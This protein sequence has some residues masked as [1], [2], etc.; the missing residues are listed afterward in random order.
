MMSG[1]KIFIFEF[2]S[3]GGFN[4]EK[5]PSSLFCEGFAMLNSIS[6]DFTKLDFEVHTLLDERIMHLSDY[7]QIEHF[8]PVDNRDNYL[9][10]FKQGLGSCESCFII[11]PEFS[12]IL[13]N[14]SSIAEKLK[15]KII[16]VNSEAIPIA[17]SKLKTSDLFK[18]Y[19][20]PSPQT[21]FLPPEQKSLPPPTKDV[22]ISS[23]SEKVGFPFII[24]PND[25]VSAESVYFLKD[26][27]KMNEFIKNWTNFLVPH[28]SYVLQ[29]Y[30]PGRNLSASLI[31]P[32]LSKNH[33]FSEMEEKR[34]PLLLSINN[35]DLQF[36]DISVDSQ[37]FGGFTPVS[38]LVNVGSKFLKLL[39]HLDLSQTQ[40][41]IGI[42]FILSQQ[43]EISFIEIN[44]RLTT[45]YIGITNAFKENPIDLLLNSQEYTQDFIFSQKN[46]GFSQFSRK[47]LLYK[48]KKSV[49][50]LNQNVIPKLLKKIPEFITPPMSFGKK[51]MHDYVQFSC[52][53]ATSCKNKAE[54]IQRM[55]EIEELLNNVQFYL[56]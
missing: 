49:R 45:S 55:Q 44:P 6:S 38:D 9:E 15:K 28:R 52:F 24:K 12:D 5:I 3:G 48:G 56:L 26:K 20:I 40:S 47:E 18:K 53:L 7:L 10:I 27:K 2:I 30:C 8:I 19:S 22:Q 23:L 31:C 17:S 41:Y 46:W 36:K 35:Q 4:K 16:S 54:S 33:P 29:E 13:Y 50:H 37:Y 34:K 1:N 51:D 32:L 42:D 43:R 11:A 39:E 21:Y 14:L 25:G